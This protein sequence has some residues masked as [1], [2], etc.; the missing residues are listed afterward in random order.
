MFKKTE[1]K[2]EMVNASILN[3]E[4]IEKDEN[5]LNSLIKLQRIFRNKLSNK[6]ISS[7]RRATSNNNTQ[8]NINT[9]NNITAKEQ[10]DSKNESDTKQINLEIPEEELTTLL[11]EYPPLSDG[12]IVSING[13][14]IDK[15]SQSIYLGEWDFTKN[16]KHGRG[17]QYWLEGSKYY[18]YWASGRANKKGKL[19]HFDGD[20]YE[21][22]RLNDQP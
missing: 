7:I 17:I 10:K 15:S 18:G 11:K 1:N 12:V 19:I 22:E 13:P 14:I 21:G 20:V 3:I 6:K 4:D 8:N 16:L 5:K 9:N 2:N